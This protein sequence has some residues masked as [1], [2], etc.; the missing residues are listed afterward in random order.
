MT[1]KTRRLAWCV[2]TRVGRS[3]TEGRTTPARTTPGRK[4]KSTRCIELYRG[5]INREHAEAPD[6]TYGYTNRVKLTYL[7]WFI[8][9]DTHTHTYTHTRHWA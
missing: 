4:S 8:T 5:G 2:H 6:S 3:R 9:L 7:L 1:P